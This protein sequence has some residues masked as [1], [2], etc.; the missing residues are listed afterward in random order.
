MLAFTRY[1][2]LSPKARII[3]LSEP[4]LS[5][6]RADGI[7]LPP[8]ENAGAV[9]D[10]DSWTVSVSNSGQEEDEKEDDEESDPSSEW[11]ELHMQVKDKLKELGGSVTPKLNWSAPQDAKWMLGT[12]DMLCRTANDVYLLLK[13]SNFITHDLEHAFDDCTSEEVS[14]NNTGDK[15][16]EGSEPTNV[17]NIP[18]HLV[19]RKHFNIN[20]SL[21]F[22]CFV[23]HRQLVCLC[24]R[25][26]THY[27]FLPELQP[28]LLRA[29]QSF[30]D[31][32]LK[33]TFPDPDFVFDVYVPP[34]HER[35][36]LIDINPFA[37]KTDP[38]LFSWEEILDFG[39]E[40]RLAEDDSLE[41]KVVRLR[42]GGQAPGERPGDC[43][44]KETDSEEAESDVEERGAE[45]IPVFRLMPQGN[46]AGTNMNAARYSAHKL[47]KD[48]VDASKNGPAGMGEFLGQW[49]DILDGKLKPDEGYETDDD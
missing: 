23:R 25:D 30:F 43:D 22:R 28:K 18:Y 47:P 33:S 10:D 16:T 27:D 11:P 13:S 8:D 12:N 4:F 39:E 44:M 19:L 45:T 24:Q 5:Y 41:E 48:V 9:S 49:R 42:I 3:A 32:K 35:V 14:S 6:L 38:L 21:E 15:S 37:Q 31:E 17:D 20:T 7:V 1:R 34:P 36:W 29:I 2:P 26:M 46:P 40:A